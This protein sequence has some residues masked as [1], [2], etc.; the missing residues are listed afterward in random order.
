MMIKP[1]GPATVLGI[2]LLA[3][4]GWAAVVTFF[5][6]TNLLI[7]AAWLLAGGVAMGVAIAYL[8]RRWWVKEYRG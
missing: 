6:A 5:L 2:I 8:M 4:V 7:G 1:K 3:A